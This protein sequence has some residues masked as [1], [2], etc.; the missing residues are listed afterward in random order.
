MCTWIDRFVYEVHFKPSYIFFFCWHLLV[1]TYL[2]I[3]TSLYT[4]I[5]F[6]AISNLEYVCVSFSVKANK[7]S[8]IKYLMSWTLIAPVH[9]Q[10][11]SQYI[12]SACESY[13][14]CYCCYV[15]SLLVVGGSRASRSHGI[16]FCEIIIIS[17]KSVEKKNTRHGWLLGRTYYIGCLIIVPANWNLVSWGQMQKKMS[18]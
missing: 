17:T 6:T 9:C 10:Y 12:D 11:Y 15:R 3:C 7:V 14:N 8:S 4:N 13:N 1:C 2:Y 18:H 5:Y 16:Y